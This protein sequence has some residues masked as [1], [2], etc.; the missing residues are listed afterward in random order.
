MYVNCDALLYI[1]TM[2]LYRKATPSS[3]PMYC[4]DIE[5][6][7]YSCSFNRPNYKLDCSKQLTECAVGSEAS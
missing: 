6:I 5:N 4:Y 7:E 3:G 1:F 2:Q